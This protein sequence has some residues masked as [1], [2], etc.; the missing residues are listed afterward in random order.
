MAQPNSKILFEPNNDRELLKGWLIHSH[1]ARDRH[2]AAARRYARSVI[3]L[4]IPT[5]IVSTV[6]GTSVF[7]ALSAK[8]TPPLWV[9]MLSLLAPVLAALQTFL[10]FGGRSDK[11]RAAGVRY[12]A[13]IR[14]LEELLVQ[15][16]K[17]GKVTRDEINDARAK[18][19]Q[20][21]ETAPVVMSSIYTNIEGHYENVELVPEAQKIYSRPS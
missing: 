7:A 14:L 17:D 5:L 4:G 3:A 15:L 18:L 11:H 8:E 12:K 13:C 20:L 21:E 2:D 10:D 9:A 16:E 1:K 6:V 19:D